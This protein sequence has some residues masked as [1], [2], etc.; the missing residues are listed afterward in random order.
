MALNPQSKGVLDKFTLVAKKIIYNPARMEQFMQMLGTPE[1]AI[2]AVQSVISVMEK[3]MPVPP[4][5]L[6]LLAV[7]I[8]LAMVDIAQE[9]SK[10]K[11]APEGIKADP[12]VMKKVISAILSKMNDS[13][14]SGQPTQGAQPEQMPPEQPQGIVAGQMGAPA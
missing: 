7:N 6:P 13:M 9:S 14:Q 5:V 12:G 3:K 1:G 11:D 10:T 2:T 8:Y 4:D